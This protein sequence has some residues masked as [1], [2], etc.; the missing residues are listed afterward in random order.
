MK[1]DN[2][3]SLLRAS[4]S[5]VFGAWLR[6]ARKARDMQQHPMSRGMATELFLEYFKIVIG[7]SED[8]T[9]GAVIADREKPVKAEI[10]RGQR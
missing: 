10:G 8:V 4:E 9:A 7:R 2:L 6:H 3:L 1:V 5:C